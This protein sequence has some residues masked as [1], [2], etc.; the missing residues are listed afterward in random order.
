MYIVQCNYAYNIGKYI[1]FE[2]CG[3]CYSQNIIIQLITI[4]NKHIKLANK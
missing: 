2:V 3:Y 4:H 1:F